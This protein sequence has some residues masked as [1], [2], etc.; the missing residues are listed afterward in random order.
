MYFEHVYQKPGYYNIDVQVR[1]L[2]CIF[3]TKSGY[4]CLLIVANFSLIV[5]PKLFE[6]L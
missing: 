4:G 3:F 6:L 1:L 5:T 2:F